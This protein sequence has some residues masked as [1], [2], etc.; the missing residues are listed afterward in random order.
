MASRFRRTDV[1]V[2]ARM[3]ARRKGLGVSQKQLARALGITYQQ[4]QKYEH[5]INRISAGVLYE[6]SK[7]LSVPVGYFFESA[8]DQAKTGLGRSAKIAPP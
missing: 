8:E 3:K 6:I 5:A 2:S 4:V 1:F 7:L